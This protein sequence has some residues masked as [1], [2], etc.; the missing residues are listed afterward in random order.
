MIKLPPF[1]EYCITPKHSSKIVFYSEEILANKRLN[2]SPGEYFIHLDHLTQVPSYR[3]SL[4]ASYELYYFENSN[5][6]SSYVKNRDILSLVDHELR[7]GALQLNFLTHHS[8]MCNKADLH[9]LQKINNRFL[10]SIPLIS[11]LLLLSNSINVFIENID[12]SKI[13]INIATNGE[14]K[15]QLDIQIDNKISD[16]SSIF[17]LKGNYYWFELF[18]RTIFTFLFKKTG[19]YFQV[20]IL[21]P[22]SVSIQIS[23]ELQNSIET[24]LSFQEYHLISDYLFFFARYFNFQLFILPQSLQISFMQ[25]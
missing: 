6:N 13:L 3:C 2:R 16:Q 11:E 20:K 15:I 18:F 5:K 21:K 4:N 12:L 14:P 1:S 24:S 9:R 19:T 23:I 7:T 17:L 10:T 25:L 22:T 8:L